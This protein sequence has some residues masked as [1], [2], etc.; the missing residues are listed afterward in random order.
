MDKDGNGTLTV[1]EIKDALAK[2][3]L[4]EDIEEIIKQADTDNDGQ[5]NYR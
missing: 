3:G 4:T 5:I 2:F 1:N